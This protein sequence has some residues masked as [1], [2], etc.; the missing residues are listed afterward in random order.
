MKRVKPARTAP[1]HGADASS[2]HLPVAHTPVGEILNRIRR[3]PSTK[4]TLRVFATRWI[5]ALQ[6]D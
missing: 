1:V 5:V 6:T 3:H 2:V 4:Q